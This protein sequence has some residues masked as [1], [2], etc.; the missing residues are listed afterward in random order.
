MKS[1]RNIFTTSLALVV[2]SVPVVSQAFAGEDSQ[3]SDK[4]STLLSEAKTQAYQLSVDA[5]TMESYTRSNLSWET[6]GAAVTQM[7]DHINA[8]GRTLTQLEE[9]RKGASSW[10]ATAIDRI[11]PLLKEIASNTQT[12]INYLNE[13]PKRLF[14]AEYKDHIEANS[15]V[16]GQLSAMITD[17]VD[18]GNTKERLRRLSAKLE[19][20]EN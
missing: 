5:A 19:I 17:F 14:V 15:D 7:R 18:Y 4:V 8:A 10:Q 3:D 11:R 1:F 13:N 20:A 9:A 12:V 16:A 2:L 6:H